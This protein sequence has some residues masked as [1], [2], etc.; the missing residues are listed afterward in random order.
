MN[1]YVKALMDIWAKDGEQVAYDFSIGI[2]KSIEM[3][4]RELRQ[5]FSAIEALQAYLRDRPGVDTASESVEPRPG[6]D[7]M[8]ASER[9]RLI[10]EA[11]I[12]VWSA[13]QNPDH[14]DP[15]HTLV[16][17]QDVLAELNDRGLDL[18]VQQPLAVIG[19]VL[20]SANGF[21]KVAR[22]TFEYTPPPRETSE[23]DYPW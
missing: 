2:V 14:Y 9:P 1:D 6:L 13:Q 4:G 11:A 17:V 7:A 10:T 15:A 5:Q 8:E 22:N 3:D 21:R 12:A 16:K 23:E 20:A 19:T 18:G